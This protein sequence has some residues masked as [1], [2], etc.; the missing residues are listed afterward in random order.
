MGFFR[1]IL[2]IDLTSTILFSHL[3]RNHFRNTPLLVI[4]SHPKTTSNQAL[5][6]LSYITRV[7]NTLNTNDLENHLIT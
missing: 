5:I 6:N 2:T 3:I 7:C 4:L 1:T